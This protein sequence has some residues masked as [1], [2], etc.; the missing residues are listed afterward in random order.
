[1]RRLK[2]DLR[3]HF[4][5]R[6]R[7]SFGLEGTANVFMHGVGRRTVK[8]LRKYD[9]GVVANLSPDIVILEMGTNDLSLSRPRSTF[10]RPL[11]CACHDTPLFAML[12][13]V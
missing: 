9:L 6:S 3:A 11:F 13:R 12:L 4:V 8:K 7:L 2:T 5:E 10:V 1:M